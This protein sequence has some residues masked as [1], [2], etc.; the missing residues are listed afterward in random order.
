M[1]THADIA[2]VYRS[3]VRRPTDMSRGYVPVPVMR[4]EDDPAYR[5]CLDHLRRMRKPGLDEV[6]AIV[7]LH[8]K[9][10]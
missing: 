9:A 4:V 5:V 8:G 2:S 7:G 1:S 6:E 3:E 10:R